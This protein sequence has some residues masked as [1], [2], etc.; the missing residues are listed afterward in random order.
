MKMTF[1]SFATLMILV[2]LAFPALRGKQ[3]SVPKFYLAASASLRSPEQ[4]RIR[5]VT[6]L[7]P[8][9]KLFLEIDDYIGQGSRILNEEPEVVVDAKGMFD[10]QVH[11]KK[12]L[13]FQVNNI[14]S[15]AFH[16]SG[17]NP[18]II[19]LVGRKGEHLGFPEN[20]L[21]HVG[22]GEYHYLEVVI[23]VTE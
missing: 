13:G 20:P 4:V 14:C 11:A 7:P 1:G 22:S 12:G 6:N 2:G 5:G 21:A 9:S 17:Q 15:I 23:V 18:E 3:P 8:G 10:V 16:P 19:R